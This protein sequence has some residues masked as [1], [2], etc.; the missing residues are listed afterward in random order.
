VSGCLGE[1]HGQHTEGAHE[2][3]TEYPPSTSVTKHYVHSINVPSCLLDRVAI[4]ATIQRG[5]CPTFV[6]SIFETHIFLAHQYTL[7]NIGHDSAIETTFPTELINLL[8]LNNAVSTALP[9]NEMQRILLFPKCS[10]ALTG[11]RFQ[12]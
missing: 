11:R 9:S 4:K 12:T 10:A 1:S 3:Q 8:L 6:D 5:H 7:D 2:I